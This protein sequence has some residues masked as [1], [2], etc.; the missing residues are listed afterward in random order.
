MTCSEDAL[1]DQDTKVQQ[2]RERNKEHARSTRLRK[3][4]YVQK[5]KDMA[6]GLR[7]VQTEETRQR[8]I[9]MQKLLEIQKLRRAIVQSVLQYHASYEQD[10]A[11]WSVLLEESFWLKQPVTPFRSFRRSE[12]DGVS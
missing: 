4:D 9:S 1:D 3:K 6:H 8:R 7:A 5:L 12:V 2:S 11:K 10:P